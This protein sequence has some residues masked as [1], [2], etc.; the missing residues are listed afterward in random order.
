MRNAL[1]WC[2]CIERRL[3]RRPVFLVILLLIPALVLAL[4]ASTK[5]GSGVV[6]IALCPADAVSEAVTDA[7]LKEESAFRFLRCENADAARRMV[8]EGTADTAWIFSEETGAA[9]RDSYRGMYAPAVTV[10]EREGNVF[11]QLA[12]EKLYAA[13]YPQLSRALFS[14]FLSDEAGTALS[15]AELEAWYRHVE[16]NEEIIAFEGAESLRQA[17]YLRAPVRGLLSILLILAGLSGA[18]L[19]ETDRE[20]GRLVWASPKSGLALRIAYT[21]LPMLDTALAVWLALGLA[22]LSASWLRE[23]LLLLLL[24]LGGAGFCALVGGLCRAPERIGMAALLLTV[25]MLAL[26][27]VFLDLHGFRWLSVLLPPDLYL[28]SVADGAKTPWLALYAAA[29]WALT[30]LAERL[31]RKRA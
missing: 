23:A 15:E 31:L 29:A 3:L 9:L 21:L 30:W 5:Q 7:L 11:L 13:L 25:A 28:R 27:P 1:H 8:A 12:R 6:T 16:T 18:A 19:L 20:A 17:G 2:L 4:N 22:G 24:T 14:E 26:C 10:V